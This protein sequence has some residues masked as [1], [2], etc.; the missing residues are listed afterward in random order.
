VTANGKPFASL[1]GGAGGA[2]P[3]LSLMF[4]FMA[5]NARTQTN[6]EGSFTYAG[7]AAGEG[8]SVGV[9]GA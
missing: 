1:T 2:S 5:S 7:G 3:Q 9:D 8:L 4:S 6:W